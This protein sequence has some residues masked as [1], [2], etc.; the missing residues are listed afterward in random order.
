M[1]KT[2]ILSA[3]FDETAKKLIIPCFVLI[4]AWVIFA[5]IVG[6][7]KNKNAKLYGA[8]KISAIVVVA[9]TAIAGIVL[10]VMKIIEKGFEAGYVIPVAVIILAL[11]GCTLFVLLAGKK[12][13][14]KMGTYGKIAVIA[15]IV[16]FA[17]CGGF[18]YSYVKNSGNA[19]ENVQ[20]V[21]LIISAV[22]L[23]AIPVII[24]AG[25]KDKM[26]TK[27][28]VFG[29]ISVAMSFALSYWAPWKLPQGGSV[30]IASLTPLLLYSFYFGP[31]KGV[32][33]CFAY[34]LLQAIQDPYIVH[35]AQ[36]LIDYPIA[37][38][39]IGLAGIFRKPIKN[40]FASFI[41]GSLLASVLRFIC[42]VISGVF[43]FAA[44]APETQT[45]LAYS[46]A[47][48]SFVFVDIAIAIGVGVALMCSKELRKKLSDYAQEDR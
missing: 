4:A 14:E 48:N 5:V 43:A 28:I 17:V 7:L 40:E 25:T 32:I 9:L 26:N 27:S 12:N 19:P 18:I 37:Y 20:S 29:A 44:Y 30:T 24:M 39:F 36:F 8:L 47:Y 15:F 6:A 13:P 2:L 45:P 38:C 23:I 22:V 46:I 16:I 10:L 33:V 3:E 35:P 21:A 34:G 1:L 42:H 11:A 41:C 31:K